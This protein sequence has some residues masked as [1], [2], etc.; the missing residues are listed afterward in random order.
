M[1][2]W[3]WEDYK[4]DLEGSLKP[5]NMHALYCGEGKQKSKTRSKH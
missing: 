4:E 5:I 2:A 3:K 1:H